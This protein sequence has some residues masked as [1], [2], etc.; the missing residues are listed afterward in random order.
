MVEEARLE[1]Y[2]NIQVF[3]DIQH[4]ITGW[5]GGKPNTDDSTRPERRL[6]YP[7]RVLAFGPQ[8]DNVTVSMG[9][10]LRKL[11]SQGHEVHVA[12]ETSGDVTVSDDN[13][14]R[15]A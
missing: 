9:G 7:K 1:Y 2:V 13:L 15:H 10:T 6:P 14:M 11:V 5:P 3:N 8:P 12:F 4:T